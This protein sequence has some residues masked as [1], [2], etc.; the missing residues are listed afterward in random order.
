MRV[1][2]LLSL[3]LLPLWGNIGSSGWSFA[4]TTAQLTGIDVSH[5]QRRIA[6]DTVASH[7]TVHFAFVKAT[8]GQDFSD[9]LFCHNWEN[10]RRV[11]I[12]R[13]AYHFFRPQGC[14]DVQALHFLST[15]EMR[16]GDLTPVL[17][18]ETTD[19]MP[20]EIMLTEMRVFLS[21]V[22]NRLGVR[23]IIYTNQ[24]FYEKYLAGLFD[25]Y[26]L[27]VAR[28]APEKPELTTGKV[29]DF[30]QYGNN[31]CVDGIDRPV[32]L[33]VFYGTEDMLERF[34]WYPDVHSLLEAR[35]A[36]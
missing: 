24:F 31:G 22:E 6:W 23:P 33:N 15:I 14:G 2:F 12:R 19:G 28:Y 13:G 1:L 29:W 32:D 18:I 7:R 5:H 10:L 25:E 9:S 8:E 36:P 21:T 16:P 27:W 17:D 4:S 20:P 26:P 3:L 30:W 34:C 35:T 11:G